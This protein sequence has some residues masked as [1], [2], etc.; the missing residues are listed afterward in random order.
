MTARDADRDH[1][2]NPDVAFCSA[3]GESITRQQRH[4]R[5][6]L[7]LNRYRTE[8]KCPA[9]GFHGEVFRHEPGE[10]DPEVNT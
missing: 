6:D 7:I 1:H 9:C 8:F 2:S 4:F 5:E 3:C 10:P